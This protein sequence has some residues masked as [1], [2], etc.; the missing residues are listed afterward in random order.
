MH[1]TGVTCTELSIAGHGDALLISKDWLSLVKVT[2][3][4]VKMGCYTAQD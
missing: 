4:L 3:T 1:I 2:S